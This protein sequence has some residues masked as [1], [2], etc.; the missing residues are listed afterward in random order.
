M[1]AFEPSGSPLN[2]AY[3]RESSLRLADPEPECGG[4][5]SHFRRQLFRNSDWA[6]LA[7]GHCVLAQHPSCRGEE[8]SGASLAGRYGP[9]DDT[10]SIYCIHACAPSGVSERT[11]RPHASTLT[12][13]AVIPWAIAL[14][15]AL[16]ETA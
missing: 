7:V 8:V 13:G 10:E 4:C 16:Q 9:E 15:S 14:L 5:R 2:S 3:E 6:G 1:G 12:E 11:T